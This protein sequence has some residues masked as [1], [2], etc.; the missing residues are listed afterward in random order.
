VIRI[1]RPIVRTAAFLDILSGV[2]TAA[3]AAAARDILASAK[4]LV[5]FTGAG[6]SADSGVPTFRGASADA[7]WGK[8]DPCQLA[9]PQGFAADPKLV[10][11]WYNWRRSQ[12]ASIQP[13]P[14]H[15][16]I[17]ALQARGAAVITQNV[18]G[19][20]ERVAP[21]GA[22]ILRLHGTIAADRCSACE[23][24]EEIDL[25]NLPALRPCPRCG[26][27]LRPAVVWFGEALDP[28]VWQA[29][30]AACRKADALL[31]VGTSGEVYPAA[32]LVQLAARNRAKI[33]LVNLELGPLDETADVALRGRAADIL[34]QLI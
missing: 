24:A 32:G 13:N 30:E 6:V 23:Y 1:S 22:T 20:H 14:A 11:D 21:P 26:E 27:Y 12:L 34:L 7:L 10:Y 4:R 29:A 8:Y 28:T 16:A 15:H 25:N 18:D 31:V 33:V 3:T 2:M 9:S 19:L 5:I 17:A